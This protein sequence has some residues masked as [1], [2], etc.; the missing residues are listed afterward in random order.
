MQL[1]LRTVSLACEL[2]DQGRYC[3]FHLC[4][5]CIF[6]PSLLA[7]QQIFTEHLLHAAILD[8]GCIGQNL[9]LHEFCSPVGERDVNQVIEPRSIYNWKLE[10]AIKESLQDTKREITR[11]IC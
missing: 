11:G 7:V 9:C 1:D 3:V 4:I 5:L 6:Q 10:S 8:I 2:L